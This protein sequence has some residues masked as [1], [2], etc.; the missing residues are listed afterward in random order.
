M[1]WPLPPTAHWMRHQCISQN[2]THIPIKQGTAYQRPT[3]D[4]ENRGYWGSG[5]ADTE[6]VR[7]ELICKVLNTLPLLIIT[8]LSDRT[9][10]WPSNLA[11]S[12]V[13]QKNHQ[14][15]LGTTNGRVHAHQHLRYF[16]DKQQSWMKILPL[17]H[18][19]TG[20]PWAKNMYAYDSWLV[21]QINPKS[22]RQAVSAM[23]QM[24]PILTWLFVKTLL[25]KKQ[26]AVA[27]QFASNKFNWNLS[28]GLENETWW[29]INTASH[30]LYPTGIFILNTLCKQGTNNSLHKDL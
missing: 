18:V 4:H 30:T 1:P 25:H 27:Q 22:W 26:R 24:Q 5:E 29:P 2:K 12:I 17:A 7:M 15:P 6:Y 19:Q 21:H 23:L 14:K 11:I 10:R 20:T 8:D 13:H 9:L 16:Q 28:C 3:R